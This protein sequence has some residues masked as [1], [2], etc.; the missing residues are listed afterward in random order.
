MSHQAFEKLN[1]AIGARTLPLRIQIFSLK[2]VAVAHHRIEE[3]H[4]VS[5]IVLHV[6]L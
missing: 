4:V 2:D 6:D 1:A 3:G 5:K